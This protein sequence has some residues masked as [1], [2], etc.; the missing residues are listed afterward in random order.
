MFPSWMATHC[1]SYLGRSFFLF[2]HY[3]AL[4]RARRARRRASSSDYT[5]YLSYCLVVSV[6][7]A[8]WHLAE[9]RVPWTPESKVQDLRQG[10]REKAAQE[11][12]RWRIVGF[13][14]RFVV[15]PLRGM[16]VSTL[17]DISNFECHW[18]FFDNKF[19]PIV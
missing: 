2:S 11:R 19:C 10:E 1:I 9:L 6:V 13:F 4:S 15:G 16:L 12:T 8:K 5:V 18:T 17:S 14:F 3:H 7:V